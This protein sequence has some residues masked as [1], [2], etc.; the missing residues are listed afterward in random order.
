[1]SRFFVW[2]SGADPDV[3]KHCE[4][5][6]RRF[7]A[8]GGTV[9]TTSVLAFLAATFT[10]HEFLYLPLGFALLAGVGWGVAIMNLDRW[11]LT[12][13][14]RQRTAIRTV[15]MALPR[16][17]LALVVGFVIA[18][19]IVLHVFENEVHA[20]AVEDKQAAF[21]DGTSRLNR[22]YAQI[23]QLEARRDA[24]LADLT[25]VDTGTALT[26]SKAYEDAVSTLDELESRA[27]RSGVRGREDVARGLRHRAQVQRRRVQDLERRLLSREQRATEVRHGAQRAQ[28]RNLSADLRKLKAERAT[29]R[30]KL[31]RE[32]RHR[33]GLLDRVEALGKLTSE[34]P[35]MLLWRLMLLLFILCLDSLP[36]IAKVLMSLGELSLYERIQ[37]GLEAADAAAVEKH[38]EAYVKASEISASLIVKEAEER[39]AYLETEQTSLLKK[40]ARIM[41]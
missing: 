25:T 3:L 1:M 12:S 37:E 39:K 23:P 17:A 22:E 30:A 24:L 41:R 35:A 29:A 32:Y 10:V 5:E 28:L 15:G 2:L 27:A 18:E 31:K 14:R 9:L 8:M 11:L 21:A 7:A 6:R 19:P 20:Q 33:V 13:I 16:I 4:R 40:A 26:T 34:H 38:S 36:A